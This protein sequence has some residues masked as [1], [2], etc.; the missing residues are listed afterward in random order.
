MNTTNLAGRLIQFNKPIEQIDFENLQPNDWKFLN[1]YKCPVMDGSPI[2]P[3]GDNIYWFVDEHG[4]Q[5][6]SYDP[7]LLLLNEDARPT[8][9]KSTTY[10]NYNMFFFKYTVSNRSV[11]E[12][13]ESIINEEKLANANLDKEADVSTM[14]TFVQGYLCAV[15]AG[16]N[17]TDAQVNAYNRQ[18]DVQEKKAKN[19]DNRLLLIAELES[20]NFNIDISSGWNND[21]IAPGGYPFSN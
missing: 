17:P 1:L 3:L 13:R 15:A 12:V 4:V 20:G 11:D 7:R 21:N 14:N 2:P 6:P 9:V 16:L 19:A 10:P 18:A 5:P 8:N